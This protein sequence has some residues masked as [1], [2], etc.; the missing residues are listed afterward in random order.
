MKLKIGDK[1][2]ISSGIG[3]GEICIV[4]KISIDANIIYLSSSHYGTYIKP[5]N[6][7]ELVN[8]KKSHPLTNIF[9]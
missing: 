8:T 4:K 9:L 6:W 3:R 1:V 2:R 7:I 5:L